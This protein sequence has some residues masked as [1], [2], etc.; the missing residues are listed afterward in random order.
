MRRIFYS[1]RRQ[2][3]KISIGVIL[4]KDDNLK[5]RNL[6]KGGRRP[7]KSVVRNES[8]SPSLRAGDGVITFALY[9]IRSSIHR[10][11][12]STHNQTLSK[13]NTPQDCPK[14]TPLPLHNLWDCATKNNNN[15]SNNELSPKVNI[16]EWQQCRFLLLR[17]SPH[18][19]YPFLVF[20]HLWLPSQR[21][22]WESIISYR[23]I[24]A[25]RD[26]SINI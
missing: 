15:N 20:S 21:L 10:L 1:S 17:S 7:L 22:I 3:A 13:Q 23:V 4:E 5:R 18:L 26:D 6:L 8:Q 16:D 2:S 14:N 9:I 19:F 25:F 11:H 24:L 12:R